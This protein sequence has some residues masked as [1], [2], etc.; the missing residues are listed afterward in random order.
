MGAQSQSMSYVSVAVVLLISARWLGVRSDCSP[1]ES[2]L[3]LLHVDSE[4]RSVMEKIDG[5]I[6][7][8]RSSIVH[9]LADQQMIISTYRS[10]SIAAHHMIDLQKSF[11]WLSTAR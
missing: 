4:P 9:V 8:D 1:F 3:C 6:A 7:I 11:F 10:T 2:R 5:S